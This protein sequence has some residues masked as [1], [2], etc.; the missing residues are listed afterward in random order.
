VAEA[1]S[2]AIRRESASI[3]SRRFGSA[4]RGTAKPCLSALR[5]ARRFPAA[6]FGPVLRSAFRRFAASLAGRGGGRSRPM[7][8]TAAPPP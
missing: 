3:R 6:D 8:V 2:P 4:P 7:P 1:P 5:A